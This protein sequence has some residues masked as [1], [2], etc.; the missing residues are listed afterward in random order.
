[1]TQLLPD[2]AKGM[3]RKL[4]LP[5]RPDLLT[6][7]T[8]E[9]A[10]YQQQPAGAAAIDAID[11]PALEAITGGE[12]PEEGQ[13]RRVGWSRP[14]ERGR[15]A[16]G[17]TPG[18]ARDRRDEHHHERQRDKCRERGEQAAWSGRGGIDGHHHGP[19]TLRST[20]AGHPP[21]KGDRVALEGPCGHDPVW[22]RRRELRETPPQRGGRGAGLQA[23]I[24]GMMAA[25][26][27]PE[28]FRTGRSLNAAY[29]M[30][31]KD[32]RLLDVLLSA[33]ADRDAEGKVIRSYA[34]IIDVTEMRRTEAAARCSQV[35]EEIIRAQEETLRALST[36]L[37]PLGGGP[38]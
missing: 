12:R 38:S 26:M 18:R 36:P 31:C 37:V 19:V 1:M 17:S 15:R 4:G 5:F 14:G 16:R 35:Q 20:A 9:A 28:F 13:R 7:Q 34:V 10:Q 27:L 30:V 2:T 33:V 21:E 22:W 32:G 25:G 6:G 23:S 29:Q 3:A 8:P 11:R 24:T